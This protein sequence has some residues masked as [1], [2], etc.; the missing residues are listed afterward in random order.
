M[1]SA[2]ETPACFEHVWALKGVHLSLTRGAE[3]EEECGRCGAVRYV[4]DDQ[5]KRP[6]D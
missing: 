6:S 5:T 3:L 4:T 1:G 2:D